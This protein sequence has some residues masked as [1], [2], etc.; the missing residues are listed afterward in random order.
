MTVSVLP[1]DPNWFGHTGFKALDAKLEELAGKQ[2]HRPLRDHELRELRENHHTR[3]ELHALGRARTWADAQGTQI[4]WEKQG[5]HPL[6]VVRK[7]INELVADG[8]GLRC[9]NTADLEGI[10]EIWPAWSYGD[11]I[12][13]SEVSVSQ[14]VPERERI[15][16]E[17]NGCEHVSAAGPSTLESPSPPV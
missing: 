7:Q 16:E 8:L 4:A 5:F 15:E 13:P 6:N 17:A 12:D 1:K 2:K 14:Q 3:N 11:D 9:L 10:R